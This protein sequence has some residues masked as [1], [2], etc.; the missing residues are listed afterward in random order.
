MLTDTHRWSLTAAGIPLVVASLGW[1]T[2]SAWQGRH[3]D[4]SRPRLLVA[5]FCCVA[6]GTAGLAF[7]GPSWGPPWL[8]FP[9][10]LVAG[11]GMGLGYSAISYLVLAQS[12]PNDVGFNTSASQLADQLGSAAL[13]GA[14]GALLVLLVT[15]AVALPV[16]MVGL[17]VLA[18]LGA[19]IAP[20]T[21]G[22][23]VPPAPGSA[24][25]G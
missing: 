17:T 25:A 5:G 2:A 9:V 8:A 14:G 6:V 20:R 21:A 13:I 22:A 1:S 15:P 12:A 18:V 19:C 4:L 16:F 24:A 11:V 3:P 7:T 10:W 23:I